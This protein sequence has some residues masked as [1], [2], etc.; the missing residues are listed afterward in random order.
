MSSGMRSLIDVTEAKADFLGMVESIRDGRGLVNAR[1]AV[2]VVVVV[3]LQ[4]VVI[5]EDVDVDDADGAAR[6]LIGAPCRNIT[7]G[8]MLEWKSHSR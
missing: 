6:V 8:N 4:V 1:R 5:V 3:A 2:V 7:R